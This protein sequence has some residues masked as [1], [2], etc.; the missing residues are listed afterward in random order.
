M[1][2]VNSIHSPKNKY[3]VEVNYLKP[4]K[5]VGSV[6][7]FTTNNIAGIDDSIRD[8][9]MNN[10]KEVHVVIRE[11]KSTYPEFNWQIIASY[12]LKSL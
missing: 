9:W 10:E 1:K 7:G 6:V 2:T 12:D 11:N 5:G 8:G 4:L 3:D